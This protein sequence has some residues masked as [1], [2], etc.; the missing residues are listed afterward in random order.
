LGQKRIAFQSIFPSQVPLN[1]QAAFAVGAFLKI[2]LDETDA[3]E[4][5][6][7]LKVDFGFTGRQRKAGTGAKVADS[8]ET[9]IYEDQKIRY[10]MA[11]GQYR[12]VE[13]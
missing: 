7:G 12:V 9:I 10:Y 11:A 1:T 6:F 3:A 2:Q 8:P 13:S 5:I 4:T